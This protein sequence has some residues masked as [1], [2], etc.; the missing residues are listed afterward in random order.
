MPTNG[1]LEQNRNHPKEWPCQSGLGVYLE[2]AS[3]LC[4]V[5]DTIKLRHVENL[6]G[7]VFGSEC[8]SLFA[9]EGDRLHVAPTSVVSAPLLCCGQESSSS[10]FVPMM[11]VGSPV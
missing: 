3:D 4:F 9:G 6:P 1:L 11:D 2:R 7:D 8:E 5:A 10:M